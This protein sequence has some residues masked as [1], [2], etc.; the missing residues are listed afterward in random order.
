LPE[1]GGEGCNVLTASVRRGKNPLGE[2][3]E[4]EGEV[5]HIPDSV[6]CGGGMKDKEGGPS[7]GE[8]TKSSAHIGSRGS[9]RQESSS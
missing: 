8:D 7:K 1:W 9:T 2:A 4:G 6:A 3:G 5:M